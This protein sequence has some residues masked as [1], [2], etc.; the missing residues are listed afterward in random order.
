MGGPG[1]G[2]WYRWNSRDTTDGYQRLDIRDIHRERL[3]V[4]GSSGTS[5]WWR[6]ERQTGSISWWTR[7]DDEL[8]TALTL[9]YTVAGESLWYQVPVAWTPCNYG[10]RR[11][12]FRCPGKSCGRRVAVLYGGKY[13]LCRHCHDLAY[14]S[15]RE[16][17]HSRYLRKTQAIRE[18][19]GGSASLMTPFPKKP[20]GMHWTTYLRLREQALAAEYASW[21]A[22]G[23]WMDR[24]DDRLKRRGIL[25]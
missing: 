15:T 5:R 13:F 21:L 11:P 25:S 14:E 6:G 18:R 22:L 8:V 19:L 2:N 12:W 10:G 7:S 1:S 17:P 23:E 3:L 4:S 20:K 9:A 24:Q 16:S